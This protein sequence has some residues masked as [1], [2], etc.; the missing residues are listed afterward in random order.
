MLYWRLKGEST[1]REKLIALF[2]PDAEEKAVRHLYVALLV[3]CGKLSRL[4]VW[5]GGF[6][7]PRRQQPCGPQPGMGIETDLTT[8]EKMLDDLGS[9]QYCRTRSVT[10]PENLLE[11]LSLPD[12]QGFLMITLQRAAW[13][14]KVGALLQ[15][16]AQMQAEAGRVPAQSRRHGGFRADPFN[17]VAHRNLMRFLLASGRPQV[18]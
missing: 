8:I 3:L 2:W 10:L 12:T 11:G 9:L 15:R 6:A 4:N 14:H 5:S 16:L 1:A 7:P 13:H 17:E 18:G